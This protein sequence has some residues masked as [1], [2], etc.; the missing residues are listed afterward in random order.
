MWD[1]NHHFE[2][3]VPRVALLTSRFL[4]SSP[5]SSLHRLKV[6]KVVPGGQEGVL[7]HSGEPNKCKVNNY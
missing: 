3:M 7:M 1:K 6:E 2:V 4:A 5:S